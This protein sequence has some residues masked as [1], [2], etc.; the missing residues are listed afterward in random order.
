MAEIIFIFGFFG[1][2]IISDNAVRQVIKTTFK[3]MFSF[4]F[5][6][7]N[8]YRLASTL[9]S[10]QSHHNCH[11]S[12]NA[13]PQYSFYTELVEELLRLK[14]SY[15]IAIGDQLRDLRLQILKNINFDKR[16][17]QLINGGIIQM[18]IISL[19]IQSFK[20][21][22]EYWLGFTIDSTLSLIILL[23]QISAPII[24]GLL[25]LYSYTLGFS[26][27][28]E[29]IGAAQKLALS[30]R[31]SIP[32]S[33]VIRELELVHMKLPQGLRIYKN[34]LEEIIQLKLQKGVNPYQDLKAMLQDLWMEYDLQIEQFQ[35]KL[36]A[37]RFMIMTLIYLPSY[38]LLIT[39]LLGSIS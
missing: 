30:S 6:H 34:Q 26:K 13:L 36:A 14:K 23:L 5:S 38:F 27:L 9:L 29:L 24:F 1:V 22:S 32:I 17:S 15:G 28:F 37:V 2:F 16:I 21:I 20:L 4:Y 12:E 8:A 35:K 7:K 3:E 19:F 31:S 11:G 39:S 10:Y 18:I 25:G 33:R